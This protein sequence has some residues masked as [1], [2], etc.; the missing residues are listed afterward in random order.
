LAEDAFPFAT[1]GGETL[2]DELKHSYYCA[3]CYDQHVEPYKSQY[4]AAAEQAKQVNVIFKGSKS[5]MR[6]L[7]K[8]D[9]PLEIKDSPDRDEAILALAFYA[10]REGYNTIMD[11]EV[12]SQ[13]VRNEGYQK[14]SWSSRGTPAEIKSHETEY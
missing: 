5:L 8:A 2:P 4:D 6:V 10:A 13:K 1:V 12:S 9:K 14:M 11:V 7:R 3:A